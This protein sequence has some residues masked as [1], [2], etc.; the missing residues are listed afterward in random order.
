MLK[1]ALIFLLVDFWGEIMN[2]S[3]RV[4]ESQLNSKQTT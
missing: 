3:R 4:H 1:R 2:G